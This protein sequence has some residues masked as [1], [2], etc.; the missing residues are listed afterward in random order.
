MS[1]VVFFISGETASSVLNGFTITNGSA[2]FAAPNDGEGGG[3]EIRNSSPTI[4]GNTIRSN[5]ACNGAGIGI[6]FGGPLIQG[7]T[8]SNNV[9][10]GCSGGTGGG[11]ILVGGESSGTR[12][13]HNVILNNAMPAGG[14]GISLFAAGGPTIQN[15]TIQGNNGGQRLSVVRV[16]RSPQLH[17][18]PGFHC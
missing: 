6:Y 17:E 16:H 3:I 13:I 8:V 7:N 15:N 14:G 12:I 5:K 1:T 2:G 4:I 9:Q 10:A 18:H 11:G